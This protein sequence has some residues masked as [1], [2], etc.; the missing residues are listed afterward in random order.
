MTEP[1][2]HRAFWAE[3]E[4]ELRLAA[5]EWLLR[6]P[7]IPVPR[8]D[9]SALSRSVEIAA[10]EVK[11][12]SILHDLARKS[13][14]EHGSMATPDVIGWRVSADISHVHIDHEVDIFLLDAEGRRRRVD[15]L[16]AEAT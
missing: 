2:P 5:E 15:T 1:N 7:K 9:G 6:Y 12:T 8:F 4:S 14:A 16:K 11:A 10:L 3:F 13:A